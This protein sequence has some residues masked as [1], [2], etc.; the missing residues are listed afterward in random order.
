VS[1]WENSRDSEL[2]RAGQLAEEPEKG[3]KFDSEGGSEFLVTYDESSPVNK[4]YFGA[5]MRTL[6]ATDADVQSLFYV[7]KSNT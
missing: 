3:F 4:A 6:G 7:R 5:F 1:I 2:E